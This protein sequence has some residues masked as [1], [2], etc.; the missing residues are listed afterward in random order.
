MNDFYRVGEL[1][2][3]KDKPLKLV[4]FSFKLSVDLK[5]L[6]EYDSSIS[7]LQKGEFEQNGLL[8]SEANLFQCTYF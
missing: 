8:L 7:D 6:T 2:K 1:Q 5:L 4:L 3:L